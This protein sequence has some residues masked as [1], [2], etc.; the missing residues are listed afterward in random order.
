ME[1]ASASSWEI[2]MEP[3]TVGTSSSAKRI[4]EPK[5]S[6]S[7]D[8]SIMLTAAAESNR[9]AMSFMPFACSS[10]LFTRSR[11]VTPIR[12]IEGKD[13]TGRAFF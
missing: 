1:R 13:S 8:R 12:L 5:A 2:R 11:T 3:I 6:A 4:S 7:T 10:L 9:S